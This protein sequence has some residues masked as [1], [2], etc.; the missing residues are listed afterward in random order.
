MEFEAKWFQSFFPQSPVNNV[1]S[2]A[3]FGYKQNTFSMSE[4]VG[5]DIGN[6]LGFARPRRTFQHKV[7]TSCSGHDGGKLGRV[8]A[9]WTE[10]V[11]RMKFVV[12][13]FRPNIF[14]RIRIGRASLIHQMVYHAIPG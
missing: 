10:N 12:E 3:F 13:L 4:A 1:Q 9:A 8:H 7:V 11:A 5:N 6:R 14:S 2:G